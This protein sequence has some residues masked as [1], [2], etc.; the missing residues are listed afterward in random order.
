MPWELTDDVEEYADRVWPLLAADP[1]ANTVALTVIDGL[2]TGRQRCTEPPYFGWY[3]GAD[4]VTGAVSRTPPFGLLLAVVPTGTV[5]E[6]VGVLT[7]A[8]AAVP[9]VNG[10]S[11]VAGDFAAEWAARHGGTPTLSMRLRLYALTGLCP[12]EPPPPG[13]AR[14][15]GESD[16]RTVADWVRSFEEEATLQRTDLTDDEVCRWCGA[17]LAWLWD[18]PDGGPVALAGRKPTAAGVARIGPVYTPPERRGRGY[19]AAVTAACTADALAGGA[20]D[21]V[22]FTDLANPTSNSIYQRIGFEPVS[23]HVVIQLDATSR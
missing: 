22:L 7:D 12:P 6:L 16:V 8:G 4:G 14:R 19:G 21:V 5:S 18:D 10:E 11:R 1:A 9:G 3:S 17:G 20:S 2:R 13:R 23:D 15:A